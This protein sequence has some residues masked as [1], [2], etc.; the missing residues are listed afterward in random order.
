M[1]VLR[2]VRDLLLVAL[3]GILA[4]EGAFLV[5]SARDN[6]AAV[7]SLTGE[8]IRLQEAVASV[9]NLTYSDP[10]QAAVERILQQGILQQEE[11]PPYTL[12]DWLQSMDLRLRRGVEVSGEV[13]V[14]NTV[15]YVSI[16][17]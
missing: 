11:P 17:P 5:L 12:A 3:L 15:L 8:V 7:A 6:E 2:F 14:G 4:T 13:D 16:V 10:S 9:S 1:K